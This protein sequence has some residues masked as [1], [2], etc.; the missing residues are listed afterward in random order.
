MDIGT[1]DKD[2]SYIWTILTQA[3]ELKNAQRDLRMATSQIDQLKG[4]AAAKLKAA[5]TLPAAVTPTAGTH[6][7]GSASSSSSKL[8]FPEI[9]ELS[10]GTRSTISQTPGGLSTPPPKRSSSSG[11]SSFLRGGKKD[12]CV[13]CTTLFV[14]LRRCHAVRS[15]PQIPGPRSPPAITSSLSSL[16]HRYLRGMHIPFDC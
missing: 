2:A 14:F 3:Q 12:C 15:R 13:S 6:H 16:Y 1:L 4:E 5:A 7:T 11:G 10:G 8:R 9:R